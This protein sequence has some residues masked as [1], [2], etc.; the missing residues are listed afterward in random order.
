MMGQKGCSNPNKKTIRV[1]NPVLF[2]SL[3]SIDDLHTFAHIVKVHGVSITHLSLKRIKTK[4]QD[5]K[6]DSSEILTQV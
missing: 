3:N 5:R 2:T 6:E 4:C 1:P